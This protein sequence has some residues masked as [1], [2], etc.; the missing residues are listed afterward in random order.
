MSDNNKPEE[1][2]TVKSD[3]IIDTI[4]KIIHEGN[5][6]KITVRKKNGDIIV[7]IPVSV[8]LVGLWLLPYFTIIGAALAVL[9]ECKITVERDK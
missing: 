6:R 9:T 7:S 3:S 1:E 4:K 2:Y 5:V 8:S